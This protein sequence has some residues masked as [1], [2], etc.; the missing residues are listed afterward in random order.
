MENNGSR[1]VEVAK[2]AVGMG[3]RKPYRRHGKLWYRP[4][5]NCFSTVPGCSDW[6]LWETMEL[7]GYAKSVET[8]SG[9]TF[10][11]TR[12]G[13]DW[14]GKQVGVVIHNERARPM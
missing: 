12:Q 14:L 10:W 11:L 7:A 4:Y 9:R 1:Y 8:K 5:R 13:L 2:H 3:K 6:D